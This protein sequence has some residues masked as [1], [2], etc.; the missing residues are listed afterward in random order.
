MQ[1]YG[2]RC[3]NCS[4]LFYFPI[5]YSGGWFR[6]ICPHC[7]L[8]YDLV[9][10]LVD[11]ELL[12][13]MLCTHRTSMWMQKSKSQKL[14]QY[15]RS[16]A[17][18]FRFVSPTEPNAVLFQVGGTRSIFPIAIYFQSTYYRFPPLNRLLLSASLAAI[19]AL[20]LIAI[21]LSL[22]PVI[23]GATS[24]LFCF[25]HFT[26]LPKI[27][28]VERRR[29]LDEQFHLRQCYQFGQNLNRIYILKNVQQNYLQLR[30]LLLEKII[31]AP[32]LYPTQI[33]LYQK[34]I[35]CTKSYLELCD[36]A[37]DKY[38]SAIR[39]KAIQIETSKFL[40]VLGANKADPNIESD[41]EDLE[42]QLVSSNPDKLFERNYETDNH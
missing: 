18:E 4:K 19:G 41:L 1:I 42:N 9:E 35:Q 7:Y 22:I 10:V 33:N 32:E 2:E 27:K 38:Q 8:G 39:A 24:A 3:P 17:L 26:A 34:A 6:T 5:D 13:Q 14:F 29:L 31:H 36:R 11:E 25:W 28:G 30:Q 23:I 16:T 20:I 37:I 21:G 12:A 15:L 40:S